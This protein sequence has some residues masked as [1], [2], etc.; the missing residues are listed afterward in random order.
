M[1]TLSFNGMQARFKKPV[2]DDTKKV[3]KLNPRWEQAKLTGEYI[4]IQTTF[5]LR[6]YKQ[7]GMGNVENIKSWAKDVNRDPKRFYGLVYW[8][9]N[10]VLKQQAEEKL[11]K[12]KTQSLFGAE[13]ILLDGDI[14][15]G[16]YILQGNNL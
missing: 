12:E 7:F 5:V 6:L 13:F 4:G 10:E 11:R 15:V 3:R 8:K 2:S 16:T 1:E 14:E 9:L